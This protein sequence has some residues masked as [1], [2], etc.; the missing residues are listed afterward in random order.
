MDKLEGTPILYRKWSSGVEHLSSLPKHRLNK[1]KSILL[2]SINYHGVG[3]VV[4]KVV[5]QNHY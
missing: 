2:K 3:T 4:N 5:S 1:K